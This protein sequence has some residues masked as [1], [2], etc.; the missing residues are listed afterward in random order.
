MSHPSD[1]RWMQHAIELGRRGT[2]T[3]G[4]NPSVGCVLVKDGRLI[5]TG[6]TQSGGRPHAEIMAIRQANSRFGE[7]ICN[8]ATAYVSLEPCAHG[9][10]TPPCADAL[11]NAGITRVVC[12]LTDPDSRVAGQG[13]ARLQDAGIIVQIGLLSEQ[14]KEAHQGFLMRV[15]H[16]RPFVTLKLASSLDGKIAT[17]T[18]ES[19]WIT[20]TR[21]R[22][23]VH[24]ERFR[25][26][27]VMVGAGTMRADDPVLNVR[28]GG[29]TAP[30]TRVVID[31]K[32]T[33]RM[34]S[35]LLNTPEYGRVKIFCRAGLQHSIFNADVIPISGQTFNMQ[36]VLSHL[37]KDGI[38]SVFCEGGGT[39]AAHLLR[40]NLVDRL[41]VFQGNCIIGQEGTPVTGEMYL[42]ALIDAPRFERVWTQQI[43][44]DSINVLKR[45]H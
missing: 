19:R 30:R 42:N 21:A 16:N 5:G 9:G 20:G 45:I 18:G 33:I 35:T 39:L 41:V 36:E 32:L 25:H 17:Q 22:E 28:L 4:E 34:D 7:G 15:Q 43:K 11:I 12:P 26:D 40:Q 6:N 10:K 2:G 1:I 13:F 3:T 31:P 8:G 27:A 14:A 37:A 29:L 38:N 23:Y 24:L 44:N